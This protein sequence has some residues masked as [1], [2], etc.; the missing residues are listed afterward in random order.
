MYGQKQI[1]Q[2]MAI[3]IILAVLNFHRTAIE[4]N[5]EI[6]KHKLIR[7]VGVG[8]KIKQIDEEHVCVLNANC[9][10]YCIR[11]P[12]NKNVYANHDTDFLCRYNC[13][14]KFETWL[15]KQ[16]I[17]QA[18]CCIKKSLAQINKKKITKMFKIATINASQKTRNDEN[19][20]MNNVGKNG[21]SLHN[22]QCESVK[23]I[24]E[25]INEKLMNINQI[26]PMDDYQCK[27][28][29]NND[30]FICKN[31]TSDTVDFIKLE[32]INKTGTIMEYNE[33]IF[34]MGPPET[35]TGSTQSFDGKYYSNFF[36][37]F[38]NCNIRRSGII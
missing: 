3:A 36:F 17:C 13:F 34:D 33:F 15:R 38:L 19:E 26:N 18:N 9:T 14:D 1:L 29:T 10:G 25:P 2:C 20:L 16:P 12:F 23:T 22:I 31:T 5:R 27:I 24:I 4:R 6:I 32:T 35:K 11:Y 8:T 30:E 37:F 21:A 7:K 28:Q